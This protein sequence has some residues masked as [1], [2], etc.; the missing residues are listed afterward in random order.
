[1]PAGAPSKDTPAIRQIILDA[2]AKRKMPLYLAAA[3]GKISRETLRVWMRDDPD[4]LAQIEYAKAEAAGELIDKVSSD[5]NGAWKILKN[6]QAEHFKDEVEV[7]ETHH[8]ILTLEA[9]DGR[10]SEIHFNAQIEPGASG[11]L[12]RGPGENPLS[13]VGD[14]GGQNNPGRLLDAQKDKQST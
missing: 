9:P 2:I 3:Y 4:F 13:S 5:S 14:T 7:K 12:L 10:T 1:M 11:P 8:T 6:L